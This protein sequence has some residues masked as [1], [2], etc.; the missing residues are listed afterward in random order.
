MNRNPTIQISSSI[1]SQPTS[2]EPL[3]TSIFPKLA[4]LMALDQSSNV[5]VAHKLDRKASADLQIEAINRAQER[6]ASMLLWDNESNQYCLMHPTL[7]DSS[8]TILPIEVSPKPSHP[9]QIKILAP[10]TNTPLLTLSLTSLALKVHTSPIIAL[11][12]LYILDTLMI[13][14]L[15]LL[16]HLHR[17][18]VAPGSY[19]AST[20]PQTPHFPPPP[21]LA[22]KGSQASLRKH[23]SLSRVSIFRS[24]KSMKSTKSLHSASVYDEDIEMQS[25]P[26]VST[27]A[28]VVGVKKRQPPKQLF[29]TDDENLPK[30]TRTVLKLLYWVFELVFWI[31][32][33]TVQVLAAGIVGAGKLITK[34]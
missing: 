32:S 27:A 24:N 12:S 5:A 25:L 26:H 1:L 14:L 3:V 9:Q 13:S 33:V 15:S 30:A 2:A 11:P 16:L 28:D 18:C 20:T 8:V 31:M 7:L 22:Y 10:E 6:E 4:G 21:T 29:A 23:R 19:P 34:L 17:S